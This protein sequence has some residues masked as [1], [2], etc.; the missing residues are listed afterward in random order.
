VRG[1]LREVLSFAILPVAPLITW[2]LP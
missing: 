2:T 1:L